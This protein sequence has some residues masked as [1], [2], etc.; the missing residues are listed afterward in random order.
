MG[1]RDRVAMAK[2]RQLAKAAA[3]AALCVCFLVQVKDS[4]TKYLDRKT[5]VSK[6]EIF[7]DEAMN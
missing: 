2:L 7:R 4:V 5:T 6:E 1:H 3:F